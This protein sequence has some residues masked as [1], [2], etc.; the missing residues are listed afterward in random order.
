[1]RQLLVRTIWP[2]GLGRAHMK[3][4]VNVLLV[5]GCAPAPLQISV[6]RG[7][8]ASDVGERRPRYRP[9]SQAPAQMIRIRTE[10]TCENVKVKT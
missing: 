8:V 2:N 9:N 7:I 1:M 4:D 6:V 3:W 5:Q 10:T